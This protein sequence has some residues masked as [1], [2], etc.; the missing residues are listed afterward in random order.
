MLTLNGCSQAYGV[1]MP[2]G[3][4][5]M[6]GV[7]RALSAIDT[8]LAALTGEIT[9]NVF[10]W[11]DVWQQIEFRVYGTSHTSVRA[12]SHYVRFW[13]A[14]G[15]KPSVTS[16]SEGFDPYTES[17]FDLAALELAD[18]HTELSMVAPRIDAPDE[19]ISGL[20]SALSLLAESAA[21]WG[22]ADRILMRALSS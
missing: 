6:E 18:L 4:E 1:C 17:P 12:M 10:A 8:R 2:R 5:D 3:H 20:V 21:E 11:V 7:Q 16:A 19:Y 22:S 13:E 9:A 15:G 14:T